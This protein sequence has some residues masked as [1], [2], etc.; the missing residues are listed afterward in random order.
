MERLPK[1][2]SLVHDTAE[3][4]KE[5]ISTGILKDFLPGE[6]QL[7]NRLGVG[8]DTLRLSLKLLTQEGWL[9]APGQGRHR[10]VQPGRASIAEV[11]RSVL[12]PVSFLSPYVPVHRLTLLELEDTRARLE[13][14][15]RTLRFLSPDIFKMKRPERHL[16]RLVKENPSAA[17]ILYSTSGPMQR[18]FDQSGLP[19]LL[20][21]SP[22]PGIQLPFVSDDWEGAAFHAGVQ[23]ARQGHRRIG[24]LEY[25]ER[26]PGL[27][28]EEEGLRRALAAARPPGVLKVFSDDRSPKSVAH[29]LESAFN[30]VDRPTALVLTSAPQVLTCYSWL[31]SRGIRVPADVSLVCIPN[32]SW[33]TDFHPPLCYYQS[34]PKVLARLISERVLE[35]VADG[36]ILRKSIRVEREYVRGATIGPAPLVP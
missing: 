30:L 7:K 3:T 8:R 19:A 16:E 23:L 5:W 14:Q 22:F 29:S 1:R 2:V 24:I 25:Q 17:W 12:L 35:L 21:E 6:L 10:R 11:S 13:E 28:A 18:W 26:R 34:E 9:A 36:R 33:F 20:F 4:L 15:G 32:D 31:A 27:V